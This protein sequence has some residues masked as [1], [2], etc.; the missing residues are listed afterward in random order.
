MPETDPENL[1][2]RYLR[3]ID[4]KVDRLAEDM[5]DVKHRLSTLE[6]T[7]AGQSRRMDRVESRLDRIERRLDLVGDP[8]E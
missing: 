7:V 4:S 2:L 8:A 1:I 3:Q 5:R 6:E